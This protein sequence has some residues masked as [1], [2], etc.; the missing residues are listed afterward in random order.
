M[1]LVSEFV[2]MEE[3]SDDAL[4]SNIPNVIFDLP[5]SSYA[6]VTFDIRHLI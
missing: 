3:L 4:Q 5:A 1:S 6:L 2:E